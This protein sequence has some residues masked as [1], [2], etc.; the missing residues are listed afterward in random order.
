MANAHHSRQGIHLGM[1]RGVQ[2]RLDE[3]L[4]A[5]QNG[6]NSGREIHDHEFRGSNRRQQPEEA[7]W[8]G[9]ML[10]S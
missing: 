10:W 2:K 4:Q 1:P 7:G 9:V 3:V 8:G 6:P 5:V